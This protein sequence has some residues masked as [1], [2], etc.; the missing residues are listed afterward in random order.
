MTNPDHTPRRSWKAWRLDVIRERLRE[1][2][3]LSF[4]AD[5]SDD[6]LDALRKAVRN[7]ID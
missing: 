2:E 7:L 1:D 4:V 3:E 5:L 6:G